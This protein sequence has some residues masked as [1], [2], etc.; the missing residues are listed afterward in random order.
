MQELLL[1][2]KDRAVIASMA[3]ARGDLTSASVTAKVPAL[4]QPIQDWWLNSTT[5]DSL[6]QA[7]GGLDV[8]LEL[9]GMAE[10]VFRFLD[11]G[12]PP[13]AWL[14][15]VEQSIEALRAL[16]ENWNGYDAPPIP[17]TLV[18]SARDA[19]R[20]LATLGIPAPDVTATNAGQ[21]QFEWHSGNADLEIRVVGAQQFNASYE[22][23]GQP[24]QKVEV[25][26]IGA[27]ALRAL[28]SLLRRL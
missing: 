20:E 17:G 2:E 12:S 8:V 7:S 15:A 9:E 3:A 11:P 24:A 18:D 22:Q 14:D 16:Q 6:Y 21:V 1:T 13:A 5:T 27:A 23:E 26:V 10:G 25:Q 19:I 4:G 28:E